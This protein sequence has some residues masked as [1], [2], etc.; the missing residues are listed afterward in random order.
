MYV[1]AQNGTGFN[2]DILHG[3]TVQPN[4]N[5]FDL[6]AFTIKEE[7]VV[8]GSYD[9]EDAANAAFRKLKIA[10]THGDG[11]CRLTEE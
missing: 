7:P 8:I 6:V 2:F 3:Y 9:T 4:G 10:L 1:F 11:I 5:G